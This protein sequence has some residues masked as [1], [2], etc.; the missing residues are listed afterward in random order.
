MTGNVVGKYEY[1]K[2]TFLFGFYRRTSVMSRGRC[3]MIGNVVHGYEYTE[4]L[5]MIRNR[6]ALPANVGNGSGAVHDDRKRPEGV[7][8]YPEVGEYL[9]LTG[10]RRKRLGKMETGKLY[11]KWQN[12]TE[13]LETGVGGGR[14]RS[15]PRVR[16]R[17]RLVN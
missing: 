15:E 17:Y 1:V 3:Q 10:K 6:S 4:K 13:I 2:K 9:G 14:L 12:R 16:A 8:M 7:R 5:E 11:G